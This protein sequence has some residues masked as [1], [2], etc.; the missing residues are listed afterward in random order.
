MDF[1]NFSLESI[2]GLK[3]T[4]MGLGING[5]GE[6]SA[7]F[8]AR[9]GADVVVT[10]LKSEEDLKVVVQ[11]LSTYKN[12]KFKLGGHDIADFESADLVIKNPAVR[13]K[14]EFLDAAKAVETDISIFLRLIKNPIIAVTGSK[15][16]STTVS[17]IY[18]VLHKVHHDALLGGNITV[19][20]LS[21]VEQ[22]ED[23]Y[24]PIVLELSSWQL[25]DLSGKNLLKPKVAV[26]TNILNDHQNTYDSLDDY[27]KDKA[28]ILQCQ[29]SSDYAIFNL[30]DKYSE[31]FA[32]N[33]KAKKFYVSDKELPKNVDGAYLSGGEGFFRTKMMKANILP[34]KLSVPGEHNRINMLTAAL[35]LYVYGISDQTIKKV[36]PS[37]PGIPHRLELVGQKDSISFYNDSAATMPDAVLAAV[38]SFR[39]P[40]YLICGGTDKNLEFSV[41]SRMP[42][43]LAEIYLLKG[44]ATVK[45]AAIL[46]DGGVTYK[47]AYGKLEEAFDQA[48]EDASLEAGASVVLLSPGAAS[49]EMFK[50]EFD[51]GDQFRNLVDKIL[52]PTADNSVFVKK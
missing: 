7:D 31:Y 25:A 15:G 3:V 27:A 20:P 36:I 34:D 46:R 26:I 51:R 24:T 52:E 49:F 43:N 32:K 19:S 10:D 6:A 48:L 47:G 1:S 30:T 9:N 2:K 18:H 13:K 23:Q 39:E 22:I 14:S 11:R 33:T 12:I 8:F 16:K 5:G 45:I 4:I 37:F 42:Q 41:F 29:D 21:F 44:S 28:E 50:N 35:S 38:K 40:V 17:A